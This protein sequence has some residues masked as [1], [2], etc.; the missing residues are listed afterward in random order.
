MASVNT[1]DLRIT[2]A[3]NLV[4]SLSDIDN[5]GLSHLFIGRS[6]AW[7]T[8]DSNPPVPDNSVSEFY[9]TYDELIALQRIDNDEI[10]HMIP[11]VNW[12][13]GVIFDMYRH[14]YSKSNPT[15]T[16]KTNLYD[17]MW[18]TLNQNNDVY[19][20]LDNNNGGVST[21]EPINTGNEA[22]YTSD[23]YQWL[24]VYTLSSAANKVVT[25]N[26]M[27]IVQNEVVS[28]TDGEIYTV[29]IEN[30]GTNY[31][32]SP[33]G[34]VNSIPNYYCKITGDGT[35]AAAK[36]TVSNG[37]ITE[38]KVV[39]S[40]SGYTYGV[41]DF[42]VN[43]VYQ[44]LS[45]MDTET[46]GL[47]PLGSGDFRSTVIIGTPG[48][49]GSNLVR[50]LGGT[51]VGIFSNIL[52]NTTDFINNTS[53]RQVGVLRGAQPQAGQDNPTTMNATYAMRVVTVN[54]A[55][56]IYK[57][58][59]VIRQTVTVDGKNKVAKGVVVSWTGNDEING[60]INYV[61]DPQIATDSDGGLY[62]FS[63]TNPIVGETTGK[64]A[65][66]AD[67]D[68]T[69]NDRVFVNGYSTPE[70]Q[71]YTGKMIYLSNIPPVI[72]SST[73]NENINLIISF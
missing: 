45:D 18:V 50:E 16:G 48:G 9:E 20:C 28:T 33:A 27:P 55:A 23:G 54:A 35:G 70:V 26:L 15:T 68:D 59:E 57:E 62:R 61:Q 71:H 58:G 66:V 37:S 32:S 46:S 14:D 7:P 30:G 24:K 56:D 73:Q 21:I 8:G 67:V 47:N 34:V 6:T 42:T 38:V 51:R 39:R 2:N 60:I 44:S 4:G 43:N 52:S 17:A 49:W 40:G 5:T 69:V 11:K 13:S 1:N 31:T 63:G 22:F 25:N 12:V 53:F 65:N 3:E 72:R 36:V 64:I 10:F 29:K 41:L 19:I